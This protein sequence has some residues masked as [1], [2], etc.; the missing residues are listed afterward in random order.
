VSEPRVEALRLLGKWSSLARGHVALAAG[1][2][3]GVGVSNLRVADFEDQIL[4]Y[5]Q[6]RHSA[7]SR[8]CELLKESRDLGDL[9]RAL[10]QR[11]RR[12]KVVTLLLADIE[13]T[14]ASFE[15]QHGGR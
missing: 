3:C 2:S 8:A 13:R 14:L 7:S 11:T 1:C 15:E 10:A 12:D 6:T 5:L 4:D 9:L